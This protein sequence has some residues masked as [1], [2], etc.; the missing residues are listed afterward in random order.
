MRAYYISETKGD[1]EKWDVCMFAHVVIPALP[2]ADVAHQVAEKLT[3][4]YEDGV[5]DGRE[6][7]RTKLGELLFGD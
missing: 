3:H 6:A 5:R 4:A 7:V 1:K 2:S